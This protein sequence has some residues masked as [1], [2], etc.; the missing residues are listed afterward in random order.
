MFESA[1]E[2][3]NHTEQAQFKDALNNLLFKC[4]IV[5][6]VYDRTRKMSRVNSDY[7]FIEKH[8]DLFNDYLSYSGLDI[9][10]DDTDGVITLRSLEGKNNLRVDGVTT[11]LIYLLR[12]YYEE[13]VVL[14]P[15]STEIFMDTNNIK[16]LLKEKG[17][18]KLNKK[19]NMTSISSSMKILAQYNIVTRVENTFSDSYYS[20]Y[21]LPSIRHA[22]SQIKMDVLTEE[23]DA[24]GNEEEDALM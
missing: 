5:R 18:I 12:Y 15:N 10:L 23:I 6:K 11:L 13:Q 16:D 24:K 3:L 22:I 1:Y 19:F 8:L 4:F 14:K 7:L 20:F 21:I 17:L 2:T 9:D